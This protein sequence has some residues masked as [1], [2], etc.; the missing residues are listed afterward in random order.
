MA[1]ERDEPA[2]AAWRTEVASIDPTTLVFLDE[3]ST[4]TSLT[5]TR[6]RAPRGARAT[7]VVPRNHGPNVSCL[8]ALTPT[9]IA[10]P[11]AIA[12]A[13]DSA[14]F[15]PWLRDWLLPTLRPGT[16]IVLD[17][18]SVHRHAAVR[19]AV[20]AAGCQVRYLP[21]YSP[22]LNPIELVF[23]KLKTYLRRAA[24]RA[25]DPLVDAIGDGLAQVTS[26]DIAGYY[27]HCG[28]A[29]PAPDEQPT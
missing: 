7:G 16:T 28:F 3:T 9:G 12:G 4:H 17:N 24:V 15:V 18:L 11:L 21:A 5:R 29:L 27:R 22:D 23:A 25:F 6:A 10:A 13:I 19:P 26:T 2:R 14:V 8:A 20:E 1:S